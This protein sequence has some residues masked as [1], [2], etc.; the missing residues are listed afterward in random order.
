VAAQQAL[1]SAAAEHQDAYSTWT[2]ARDELS[3]EVHALF[4]TAADASEG[5]D[6]DNRQAEARP[7][8]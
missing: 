5:D 6:H 8:T 7:G 2:A 1:D 4:G 3:R